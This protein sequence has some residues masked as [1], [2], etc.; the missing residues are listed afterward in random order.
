MS[1]ISF[2]YFQQQ[3]TTICDTKEYA[4]AYEFFLKEKTHFYAHPL[5]ISYWHICI[6]ALSGKQ[7]EA[8]QVFQEALDQGYWFPLDRLQNDPYLASVRETA[9]FQELLQI[10]QQ[11]LAKIQCTIQPEMYVVQ[12]QQQTMTFSLL[13]ALHGNG[14]NAEVTV[15]PWKDITER[16][17]LLAV[18]RS[19]QFAGPDAYVWNDREKG[20]SEV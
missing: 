1:S 13:M 6:A 7:A 9:I 14:T 4:Q 17:W 8:L 20:A 3:L 16:G 2:R 10:C 18:P 19:T 11:H 12:P 5:Q 15:N